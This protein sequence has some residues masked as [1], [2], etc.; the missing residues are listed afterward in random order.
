MQRHLGVNHDCLIISSA[1]FLHLSVT[2]YKCITLAMSY[3]KRQM[4]G[5]DS[6]AIPFGVFIC[7]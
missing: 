7:T 2:V 1:C 6:D 3:S 4:E 5:K